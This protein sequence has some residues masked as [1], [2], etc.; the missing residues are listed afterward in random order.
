[1]NIPLSLFRPWLLALCLLAPATLFAVGYEPETIPE[2]AGPSGPQRRTV[3]LFTRL[4]NSPSRTN[5]AEQLA[6]AQEL[7][8]KGALRSALKA[9][10]AAF[11]FWQTS[12]EAP[13]ALLAYARLLEK[14]GRY[15]PAFDEYQYLIS[16]YSGLFP[17]DAV[18]ESQYA[19]ANQVRTEVYGRWFFG[20]GFVSPERAIPY[21]FQVAS[22]APN[23]RLAPEALFNVGSIF[24]QNKQYPEAI[25]VYSD[26]QTRYPNTDEAKMA[27]YQLVRCMLDITL[28]QPNNNQY[29][30]ETRAALALFLRDHPDSPHFEKMKRALSELDA[31]QAKTLME[32]AY[33]YERA[34]KNKVAADVYRQLIAEFPKSPEAE[35]AKLKIAELTPPA[36]QGSQK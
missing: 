4:F 18:I 32:R 10:K 14:T 2:G 30:A 34:R 24:Q 21:Y 11:L 17:Y 13:Q 1:M 23:W 6:Y 7:E 22:N 31:M 19:L 28:S 16:T 36:E 33:V 27:A 8:A 3:G 26:V 35:K 9:Y 12:A 15:S 29:R 25:R 5:A 20:I